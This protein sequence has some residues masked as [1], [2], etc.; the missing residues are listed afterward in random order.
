[1]KTSIV[2]PM[3][4]FDDGISMPF[5]NKPAVIAPHNASIEPT[6]R[7]MPAVNTINV[8]PPEMQ[9]FTDIWRITFH[10]LV[11]VKNLSDNKLITMQRITNAIN[12]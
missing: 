5:F 4:K 1:M 7:S 2:K 6:E 10:A 3:N 12:D 11:A 9:M 8:I